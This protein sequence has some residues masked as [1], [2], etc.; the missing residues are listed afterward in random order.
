MRKSLFTSLLIALTLVFAQQGWALEQEAGDVV[1]PG[2]TDYPYTTQPGWGNKG[3]ITPKEGQKLFF[4]GYGELQYGIPSDGGNSKMDFHRFVWGISYEIS[5]RITLHTEV[6][7]EHAANEMELEFAYL[8]Y[9]IND[10]FN[11]RAGA[12]L[13]PVGSLNEFHEPPLFYSVQRPLFH[14]VIIPTTWQEGGIG[15]YGAPTEG[16]RYRVYVVSGL[17]GQHFSAK[18]GIRDGRG[19]VAGAENQPLTGEEL[20]VVGRFEYSP[21]LGVSLGTSFYS[22]GVDQENNIGGDP[23]VSIYE[24]DGRV[25]IHGVDFQASYAKV[26]INDADDI[27]RATCKKDDPTSADIT[28]GD[29]ISGPEKCETVAEEL[30][31]WYVEAAYHLGQVLNTD[32]D[33]VP[34]VR[35]SEVNTQ[36]KVSSGLIKTGIPFAA[37]KEFDR[38]ILTF[39]IAAYPHPQVALKADF[40]N[41]EDAAG[42][43]T[44]QVNLGVTYM[45]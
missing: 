38:E 17:N 9:A 25:R 41:F 32:W 24:F 6:D 29:F 19:K 7:F 1:F 21:L 42:G 4:H 31:G 35:Y 12:L 40:Q 5:D 2:E 45:F 44:D 43:D 26:D 34:F 16:F 37:K 36:D 15:I 28:T 14:K 23:S 3:R 30:S 20:A 27:S 13:M 18:K 33:F 11:V 10:A 8:D 39:G 22:G